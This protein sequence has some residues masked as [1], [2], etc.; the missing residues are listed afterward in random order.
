M[1]STFIKI[2]TIMTI[3]NLFGCKQ[4]SDPAKWSD[5]QV[6]RWFQKG[7]WLEGWQI[8]PDES[9][10]RR[11]LAVSYFQHKD[12]WH[13]AFLFLK[14]HDLTKMEP[15]RYDIDGDNLYAPLSE[16][17]TKKEEG[18]NY[19]SHRKYIDIQYV[20]SGKELIGIAK[21][22]DIK[23]VIQAYD[24]NKDIMF[25]S[26]NNIKNYKADPGRFFVF[27][28]TDL[29]RPG[30]RDGDSTLVRKVVVKVKID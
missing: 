12:R 3:L 1:K 17:Y 28:P 25:I 30:L 20:V 6:N 13:K 27:F 14:D 5:K 16:Y 26:V 10:D 22:D 11:M 29:H 2:I 4:S 15:K 21:S 19:E 23:E 8:K 7:E 18:A 9:I 24:A